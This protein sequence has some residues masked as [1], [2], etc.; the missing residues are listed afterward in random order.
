MVGWLRPWEER[1]LFPRITP[2]Q[3]MGYPLL[4]VWLPPG[5]RERRLRQ[6]ARA[7][8]R[9]GVR[10]VMTA[11]GLAGR[12][13]LALLGLVPVDPLPLCRAMGDELALFLLKDVPLRARRVALRGDGADGA[14]WA[15]A[16]A[17][18]PR[19]GVLLLELDRGEEALASA[20]RAHYGAAPV[21]L[22][23]GAPPQVSVELAPRPPVGG[24]TLRLWGEP[25]MSGLTL[26]APVELPAG[27]EELPFLTLLWECGRL[28]KEDIRVERISAP[29]T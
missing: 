1:H 21:H 12:E 27:L 7:L 20:L 22:G 26:R 24:E 9:R 10:R 19:V 6:G 29:V 2:T 18:C 23:C 8:A 11:P 25:D 13:E 16:E 3:A 15:M 28:R 4:A 17:L 5:S 14:V